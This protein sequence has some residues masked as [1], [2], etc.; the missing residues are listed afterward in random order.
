MR[1]ILVSFFG[2]N[3]FL[4][5]N[6][7]AETK[8]GTVG[9]YADGRAYRVDSQGYQLSDQIAELEATIKEQETQILSCEDQLS[10]K[11]NTPR[12]AQNPK[13]EDPKENYSKAECPKIECPAVKSQATLQPTAELC[14][15]FTT[16]LTTSF[17]AEISELRTKLSR[18]PRPEQ[19]GALSEESIQLRQSL[20]LAEENAKTTLKKA[21]ESANSTLGAERAKLLQQENS[22]RQLQSQLSELASDI[23]R[24][25]KRESE[26]LAALDNL[27]AQLAS[28]SQPKEDRARG[29]LTS[30]LKTETP[31]PLNA[32]E[33]PG[34]K[35]AIIARLSEIQKLII[36]RKD[37]FDSARSSKRGVTIQM[38]PLETKNG[39]SLDQLRQRANSE[40][41]DFGA[42]SGGLNEIKA[43]LNGDIQV[44]ERLIQRL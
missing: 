40:N 30:T 41:T 23:E 32:Q 2:L 9:R 4:L 11:G 43:L 39:I 6:A 17:G 12:I 16:T 22:N 8:S 26:L 31:I 1:L 21:Q 42:L 44:M 35:T 34:N 25:S 36:K 29:M 24:K 20:S 37:I 38:Q 13:V 7:S 33:S 18:A 15:P 28:N 3:F 27:S 10:E 5:S 14:A 19:I